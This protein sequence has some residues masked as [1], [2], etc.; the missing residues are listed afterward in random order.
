MEPIVGYSR[1]V[2]VGSH[3]FVSGTAPIPK[4]GAEAPTDAYAQTRLCLD[5]VRGALEEAG[6]RLED[7]VRTRLYLT[8]AA[9]IGE[10]GRAHGEVF[11]AIR[12]ANTSIVVAALFDPKWRIEIEVDA[13]SPLSE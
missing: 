6:S 9:D 4:D 11:H 7:V 13:L 3:V 10:V 2:V 12:P 8:D 5:I 1:A